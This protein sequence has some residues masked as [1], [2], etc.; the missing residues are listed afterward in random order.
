MGCRIVEIEIVEPRRSVE[1]R[2]LFGEFSALAVPF[3]GLS[4]Q[5]LHSGL[6]LVFAPVLVLLAILALIGD[7]VDGY[8]LGCSTIRL[9]L[10]GGLAFAATCLPVWLPIDYFPHHPELYDLL[11]PKFS[12]P[13]TSW[14]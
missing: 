1:L 9:M 8:P 4:P 14:A 7:C 11:L 12:A 6:G 5:V 13:A 3:S 2:R 10:F